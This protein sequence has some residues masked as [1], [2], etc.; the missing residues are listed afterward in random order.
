M[1]EYSKERVEEIMT[2]KEMELNVVPHIGP[3]E[4]VKLGMLVVGDGAQIHETVEFVSVAGG[5]RIY[6]GPEATVKAHAVLH[7]G[8]RLGEKVV[9]SHGAVLEANCEIGT[10]TFIG[11]NCVLRPGTRIGVQ[12]KVGHLTVFEGESEIGDRTVIQ[13]QCNIT[14]G[15]FIGN[16]VFIASMFAGANDPVMAHRRRH[17]LKYFF[18]PYAIGDGVRIAMGVTLLAGVR[19]GRNCLIGAGAVVTKDVE[20]AAIMIGVPA[21]KVGEVKKEE[22]L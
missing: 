9:I 10:E 4:A 20:C 11:H 8:C 14:K 13:A 7:S 18:D 16:D 6:I 15:V 19:L 5:E 17:I 1:V 3:A 2:A 22:W 21:R 12:C